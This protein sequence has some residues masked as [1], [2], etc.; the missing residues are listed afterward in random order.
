ML[1]VIGVT[2]PVPEKSSAAL[3]SNENMQPSGM[4]IS[5]R[6]S[7]GHTQDIENPDKRFPHMQLFHLKC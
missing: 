2:A 7:Q 6:T 4:T 1:L 3:S 5:F